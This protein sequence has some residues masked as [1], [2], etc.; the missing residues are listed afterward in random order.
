MTITRPDI[1]QLLTERILVIDGSMGALIMSSNPD[2]AFYRGQRFKDHPIDVKNAT[3]LLVLTQPQLISSIHQQYLDAGADIIET[4]TFNA[5]IVSLEEFQLAHLTREINCVGAQLAR[6][7]ADHATLQ[8]PAKPRYVAGSIGPTKVQ[9]SMNADRPG[10]RPVTFDHLAHSYAEQIRG[11]MDGGCDLL[12][13]ET[14]FDT[15]NMKACLFAIEQVFEE[16]GQRLPV[17]ISGTVFTGGVTLLGQSV[18]AFFTSIEHFPALSVGFNCALGPKQMKPYLEILS[19]MAPTFISCYPN[20]GMPDGM[21]GFDSSA[22]EFADIL[23]QCAQAGLLNIVGGCCGTTPEFIRRVSAAVEGLPPRRIPAHRGISTYS[24]FDY[25]ALTPDSRFMNVGERT[26][27]TGSRRFARLIRE[28]KYDE[29]ISIAREQVEGGANVIDVNMDEGLL[30]GPRC[31]EKFLWL[32]HDENI[33]VPI[34][35][36]SSDWN[37]IEAGL[38]C[39]QGKCIV[40]SISLKEGE[41]KFLQQARLIRRFGAAVIVMAFDET[42]QATTCDDKVRIC[43][44]AWHLLTEKAGFPSTDIIFDANIL[45]V[46]TGM[47]EHANYA[48]EFIEAVRRIKIEC[49]GAKTSGGVS[50]VSFSFRGNEVVREA[51]NAAFLYHAIQAGLDMGIVNPQ[52]LEVYE[53]IDRELLQYI[54]DVLL[55][56]RPDATER[57]IEFAEKVKGRSDGGRRRADEWRSG[58]V[59]ERLKHALLRGLTD[60]IDE[61]TE[62]ARQKYGRP[63]DIIQGPLMDG[64]NVIGE[65]FGAGKMFLPQVVKSARVMKKSVAWLEPFMEAEKAAKVLGQQARFSPT[66]LFDGTRDEA[67][68]MAA[69]AQNAPGAQ[70]TD[71]ARGTFLIATVKGDVHDIGKNI[72]AVVLRCNNFRVI[73]LGVMVPCERILEEALRHRADIIGLSGLITP[74]LEEMITVARTME[75]Q[76]FRIPLLIGGAT[77]SARHTA[78]KI[79]P[80]YNQPVVHVGDASL[81]VAVVESLLDQDRRADFVQKNLLEQQRSRASFEQRQQQ[82]LVP[83]ATARERRFQ[84]DWAACQPPRP[85]ICGLQVIDSLPLAELVP[86]IDWSPFFMSWQL[87]GKYPKILQD[88]IVGEEARRLFADAQQELQQLVA[89]QQLTAR[90]VYGFWPANSD[91]D[92]IVLWNNEQRDQELLRFPMLRQQWERVGQRDF[93]CLADYVAP[94]GTPDYIGAFALTAGHGCDELAKRVEAEGDDYRAI[95][96]KALADR[97]AEAFAEYLHARVRAEWEYGTAEQFTNEQLINEEYR[98]IRPAFGYP[99]CPDHLPKGRLWQLLDVEQQIGMSLTSSYAMWPASSVSGLYFSHPEA[100]YFSV[101]RVTSEQVQDYANRMGL[102]VAEMERWLAPNLGYTPQRSSG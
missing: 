84:T 50:N 78:V 4:D 86:W 1:H 25:V 80:V 88:P 74:S 23:R 27:V 76:G 97:L 15:L 13:P 63:L 47:E 68:T 56:R 43:R 8:N 20:A 72:V 83:L 96:I 75:E 29:A 79:A 70:A 65:L 57:L 48:V 5:N 24:G 19:A 11:L 28:E 101:D 53:E 54:E 12:L 38:K 82:T 35:I 49:P 91:G 41:E 85:Q 60:F 66:G 61:D 73:D 87:I 94:V 37:V 67:M 90:A 22:E 32:L 55:N 51:M 71:S 9:L 77:T 59:E 92:D 81:S 14:S 69:S 31:M 18:E 26:N 89:D 52:Q 40:N 99:S 42:G 39:C 17:M 36:D 64:M 34:M 58:T 3:D 21:G 93:R 98:G 62:E 95:M 7:A 30:D 100:R 16:R 44:R 102:T 45:T 6:A 46:G 10:T 2:E 33:K